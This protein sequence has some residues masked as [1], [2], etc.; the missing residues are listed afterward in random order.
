MYTD[1]MTHST[2]PRRRIRRRRRTRKIIID[3]ACWGKNKP[4]EQW[5]ND[6]SSFLSVVIIY[7]G[8]RPYEV[9]KLHPSTPSAEQ[10]YAQMKPF[11]DDP[12]VVAILTAYPD[13]P[14]N[15]DTTNAYETLVY[16]KAK[17][18]TVD[19]VITH[20]DKVFKRAPSHMQK[21][22]TVPLKKV[23]VPYSFK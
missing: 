1:T 6:L 16:P 4:L 15:P 3:P 8:V 12:S 13:N 23:R 21:M 7:K 11:D 18:K 22:F 5:W 20:Y 19:Y 10:F 14:D 9:I 17:D 2:K